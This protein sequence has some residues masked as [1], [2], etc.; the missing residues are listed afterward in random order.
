MQGPAR[1]SAGLVLANLSEE[2]QVT[3]DT[4]PTFL[5]A[6]TDD[7]AVPVMNSVAFYS[8]LVKNGVSPE[9][10][11]FQHGNHGVGLAAGNP[12]LS[13]WPELLIK[14]MR[15]RGHASAADAEPPPAS[16]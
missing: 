6:T 9:M 7:G 16:R 2:T 4:P 12:Q 8:A 14:W 11:L 1:I 10:H 13:M 5:L 15:E 3:R